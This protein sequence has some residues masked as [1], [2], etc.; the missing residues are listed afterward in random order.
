MTCR[1]PD[2]TTGAS[3]LARRATV[4]L[5]KGLSVREIDLRRLQVSRVQGLLAV[6]LDELWLSGDLHA[7]FAELTF[8]FVGEGGFRTSRLAS[9]PLTG[10]ALVHGHLITRSRNLLW[11]PAFPVEPA[12]HAKGVT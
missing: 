5:V 6:R 7:S 4:T 8:D 10:E 2:D 3:R 9:R 1:Y 12:Y 11:D